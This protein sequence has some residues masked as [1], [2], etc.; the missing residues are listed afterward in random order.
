MIGWIIGSV[1]ASLVF[2]VS[3]FVLSRRNFSFRF[4]M[5]YDIR[6]YFPYEFNFESRFVDNIL[7]NCSLVMMA[8]FSISFFAVSLTYLNL[9][10]YLLFTAIS[11]VILTI[12]IAAMNFVPLK[13]GRIHLILAVILFAISFACPGSIALAAFREYQENNELY[14]LIIMIVSGIFSLFMFALTMNPKLTMNIKMETKTNEKGEN[15]LT[16]P[17][18]I[19]VAFTEWLSIFSLL[20]DEILIVILLIFIK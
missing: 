12:L 1:S 5:N 2:F 14:G 4:K 9:N 11:G 20:L 16:R 7:G 17:K 15:V 8:M 13:L 10:S 3:Y 19:V 18:Y 6:N